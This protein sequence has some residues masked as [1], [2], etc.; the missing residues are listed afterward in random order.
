MRRG[1]THFVA[2]VEREEL[3]IRLRAAGK[4]ADLFS[5]IKKHLGLRNI[6]NWYRTEE[7]VS[8]TCENCLKEETRDRPNEYVTVRLPKSL[9]DEVDALVGRHGFTSRAEVVKE[10]VRSWLLEE[11]DRGTSKRV[12]MESKKELAKELR[13]AGYSRKA[14]KAILKWY[15]C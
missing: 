12:Q 2:K 11:R 5:K 4:I 10:A 14:M 13:K 8:H 6:I 9:V 1:Y 15:D 7:R 3:R